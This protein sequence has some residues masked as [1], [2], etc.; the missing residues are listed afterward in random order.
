MPTGW[1]GD[2]DSK[3]E[4]QPVRRSPIRVLFLSTKK[5][6]PV[7]L[8]AAFQ[9]VFEDLCSSNPPQSMEQTTNLAL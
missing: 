6:T 2:S 4:V 3:S 8:S 9:S 5:K 7:T 1:D